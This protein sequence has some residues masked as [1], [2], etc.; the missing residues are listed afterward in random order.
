MFC[1]KLASTRLL[2][3][4]GEMMNWDA[5][6]AV[7]ELIG[8]CLVVISLIYLAVQL[9]QN[10]R[11][12]RAD[13]HQQWVVMNSAQNL[14][15]PQNPEFA[16]L[17]AKAMIEPNELHFHERL[18]VEAVILNIMITQE[19]LFFQHKQGAIDI[20]FLLGREPGF[21]RVFS[22]SIFHTWWKQNAKIVLDPR[23]VRYVVE[24]LGDTQHEL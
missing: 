8:G 2:C 14:L 6:G 9:R 11:A 17:F 16:K 21:K 5:I 7:A 3:V 23:F 20:E 13:T 15:F 12:L 19:A 24:L 22:I 4:D 18:Q 10:T 1:A